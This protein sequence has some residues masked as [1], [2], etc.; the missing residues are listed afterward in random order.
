MNQPRINSRQKGASFERAVAKELLLLTGV[1][2][3]RELEQYRAADHGDLI[4]DNPAWPFTVE[5][6]SYSDGS[7]CRAEWK[8]QARKAANA[9][10]KQPVVVFKFNRRPIRCAIPLS[11]LCAAWPAE[12]WAEI[13]LEAL[14]MIAAERMSA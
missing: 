1:N 3:R 13:T 14:A 8:E 9:A 7:G 10:G 2:F 4:A 5:C 6:K 11:A 12:E